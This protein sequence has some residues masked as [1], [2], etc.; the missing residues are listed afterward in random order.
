MSSARHVMASIELAKSA[1]PAA[2]LT[3]HRTAT[4]PVEGSGPS[5]G[6]IESTSAITTPIASTAV[7]HHIAIHHRERNPWRVGV[8]RA[9]SMAISAGL[10]PAGAGAAAATT[11]VGV[12]RPANPTS[13]VAIHLTNPM[14]SSR[15]RGVTSKVVGGSTTWLV[16]LRRVRRIRFFWFGWVCDRGE[17]HARLLTAD[18]RIRRTLRMRGSPVR[19]LEAG[20][21]SDLCFEDVW[22]P[23]CRGS[24]AGRSSRR[25]G[26]GES[27]TK[28]GSSW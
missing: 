27:M 4:S 26:D 23:R 25:T 28:E 24:C 3:T 1:R 5:G 12:G 13:R 10:G 20:L 16:G 15:T 8:N 17:R 22:M 11:A 7:S 14:P 21:V 9:R 6:E 18:R 19:E 2:R